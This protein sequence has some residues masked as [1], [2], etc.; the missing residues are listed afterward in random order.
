[1]IEIQDTIVSFELFKKRFCCDLD[2]C[3]GECCI[4]GDSGAPVEEEEVAELEKALPIVWDTLSKECQEVINQQGVVYTDEDGDL[5]TS[6]VNGRE[7]VFTYTDTEG[8]CKCA[9][10]KAYR[11]GKSTFNK[12]MSCYLYPV[13]LKKYKSFTA[14][15][16]HSWD[17]CKCAEMLGCKLQLPVYKFLKEPLTA[18][19]G[20]E[21][22]AEL[23]IAAEAYNN[24]IISE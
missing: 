5:V 14:V 1:M 22:Y 23:E 17:I 12:P 10:E 20:K 7:C 4:E 16:Y 13:R 8:S 24:E 18:R 15:N 2:T 9:L 3:K 6:I 11:E 21:W 19:F